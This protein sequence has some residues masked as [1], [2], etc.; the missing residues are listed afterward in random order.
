MDELVAIFRYGLQLFL[1]PVHFCPKHCIFSVQVTTPHDSVIE[2]DLLLLKQLFQAHADVNRIGSGRIGGQPKQVITKPDRGASLPNVEV[3][4]AKCQKLKRLLL[5]IRSQYGGVRHVL[6]KP[7]LD[8][9]IIHIEPLKCARHPTIQIVNFLEHCEDDE[10]DDVVQ[11]NN[12]YVDILEKGIGD[13]PLCRFVS[14]KR[15][16]KLW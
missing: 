5:A 3:P 11:V 1:K 10:G 2:R 6:L 9:I 15:Y 8:D 14:E 12:F 7:H 16:R 13:R 4:D